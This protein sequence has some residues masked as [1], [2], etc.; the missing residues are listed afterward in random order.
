MISSF[1]RENDSLKLSKARAKMEE[2]ESAAC[3]EELSRCVAELE[4][5]GKVDHWRPDEDIAAWEEL[6]ALAA[7]EAGEVEPSIG[8]GALV[9]LTAHDAQD[10]Q[11]EVG[12]R[13]I[14]VT[15][16]RPLDFIF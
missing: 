8:D 15:Y 10:D 1:R 5:N 11:G 4:A 13:S 12:D 2:Q 14:F 6:K 16:I 7:T 3:V 9:S